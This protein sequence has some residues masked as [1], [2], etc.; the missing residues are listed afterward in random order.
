MFESWLP[1][2]VIGESVPGRTMTWS[3]LERLVADAEHQECLRRSLQRCG[4][5]AELIELARTLGYRISQA[6]LR[7]ARVKHGVERR[8]RASA[9]GMPEIA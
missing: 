8:R 3:E 1:A 7:L 2:N 9:G 4:N 5:S 6:D